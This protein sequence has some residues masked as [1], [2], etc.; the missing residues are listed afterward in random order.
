M[1]KRSEP[2]LAGRGTAFGAIALGA[3]SLAACGAPDSAPGANATDNGVIAPAAPAASGNAVSNA[4]DGGAAARDGNAS[5]PAGGVAAAAKAPPPAAAAWS[6]TGYALNGTEPFWGGT[7]TGTQLLYQ[8]PENQAGET[9]A[10]SAAY[11]AAKE[12]YTGS[13]GGQLLVLTLTKGPCSNGM[14]DQT[15]AYSA[16]LRVRGETRHGCADPR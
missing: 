9:V 14:S 1:T 5:A 8:T 11:G 15:F 10:T 6:P 13:L 16:V 7:L 12:V 3:L 2:A 4:A